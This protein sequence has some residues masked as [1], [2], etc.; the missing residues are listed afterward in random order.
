MRRPWTLGGLVV[1]AC[2]RASKWLA[3]TRHGRWF[4]GQ[5]WSAGA[6]NGTITIY[7]AIYRGQPACRS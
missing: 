6:L 7:G 3:R 5:K 2:L 4:T 1:T